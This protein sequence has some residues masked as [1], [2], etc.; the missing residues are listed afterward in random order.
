MSDKKKKMTFSKKLGIASLCYLIVLALGLAVFYSYLAVYE[1]NLPENIAAGILA[2]M[3]EDPLSLITPE[4]LSKDIQISPFEGNDEI[5]DTV[6]LGFESASPELRPLS[7]GM[8]QEKKFSVVSD[9]KKLAEFSLAPTGKKTSFGV[10]KWGLQSVTS[11]VDRKYAAVA[12]ILPESSLYI[13]GILCDKSYIATNDG[14]YDVYAISGLLR[15]PSVSIKTKNGIL[16]D[17]SSIAQADSEPSESFE[18]REE[19]TEVNIL[20]TSSI[21][22]GGI[23][24]ES[25][26]VTN[27]QVPCAYT[28][29]LPGSENL[30]YNT[31]RLSGAEFMQGISVTDKSGKPGALKKNDEGI[32]CEVTNFDEELEEKFRDH[33]FKAARAYARYMTNDGSL[34]EVVQ[35]FDK[36]SQIYRHI[37]TSEVNWYTT[38]IG[39]SFENERVSEF[40]PLTDTAFAC[41]Y[42]GT[43]T[44]NRTAT[45]KRVMELD[46]TMFFALYEDGRYYIYDMVV[47]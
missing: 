13:N 5:N 31:V 9:G 22:V 36:E 45:D 19:Y 14:V 46:L 30:F 25:P 44:V 7:A 47:G 34:G 41:R 29:H 10:K 17:L 3:L 32:L 6:A 16:S 26:V 21:Y 12:K 33:A 23:L 11:F 24:D 40:Y 27:T 28:G 2:D 37:R 35:Y 39:Y 8:G 18:Y 4:N 1:E 43:Q 15:K 38:H 20:G 42:T